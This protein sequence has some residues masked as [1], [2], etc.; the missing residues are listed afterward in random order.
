SVSLSDIDKDTIRIGELLIERNLVTESQVAKALALQR[1]SG[2]LFG[3]TL[4]GM[5]VLGERTLADALAWKFDMPECDLRTQIPERQAVTLLPEEIARVR[6]VIPVTLN[7][8]DLFVA[9]VEP[10]EE[11]RRLLT[12]STGCNV[13]MMIATLS[14]VREAIETS[15]RTLGGVPQFTDDSEPTPGDQRRTTVVVD[16]QF[17]DDESPVT[18]IV[19]GLLAQAVRDRATEIHLEP[20]DRG[21]R[22]RCRIDGVMKELQTLPSASG[23]GA[24]NRLKTIAQMNVVEKRRPQDGHFTAIIGALPLDVRVATISTIFGETCVLRILDRSRSVIPLD[25][26]GLAP[27]VFD[28]YAELIRLPFGMVVCA[29]P[30]GSGKTTTLYSTLSE[31]DDPAMNIMTVEDPVEFVLPT[32]NQIETNDDAGVTFVTG[33]KSILRQDPDVILVGDIR[34]TETARIAIQSATANHLVFCSLPAPD[35]VAALGR[36]REMG[37]EPFLIAASVAGIISQ[38][39]VRRICEQCKTTYIPTPEERAFYEKSGDPEKT[40]FVCGSG[41]DACSYTGYRDRIGVFEF[42]PVTPTIKQLIVSSGTDEEIRLAASQQGVLSLR[43]QAT[44]LVTQDLTT[45]SEIARNTAAV[46]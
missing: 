5:G 30:A 43:E 10:S 46:Y 17:R 38:R 4:V 33:L 25:R 27:D 6:S 1:E 41:C 26:L 20:Q 23:Q 34:D 14:S 28:A 22:I 9:V 21:M 7:G 16:S 40:S 13:H 31:L 45:I 12:E 42:L 18:D 24:V 15:Y 3:Q 2:G 35:S 39:L 36:L 19:N 11:L 44:R 32:M 29:G 37:V 8:N